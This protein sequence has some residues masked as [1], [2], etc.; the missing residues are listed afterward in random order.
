MLSHAVKGREIG[1]GKGDSMLL[2]K[3]EAAVKVLR[4]LQSDG[5]S[6]LL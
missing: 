3:R 6:D 1:S 2:A 4:T 5:I